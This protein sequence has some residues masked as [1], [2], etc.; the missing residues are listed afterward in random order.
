MLADRDVLSSIITHELRGPIQSVQAFLGVVL[1][2]QAGELT[3]VQKDFLASALFASKR[4]ER[5]VNDVH[6]LLA[7]EAGFSVTFRP[8]DL[9]ALLH[10]CVREL[11]LIA[12]GHDVHI[13]TEAA[14]DESWIV[15]ADPGRVEQIALN[16]L[17]NA[18]HYCDPGTNVVVRLR[19]SQE[20]VVCTVE[21]WATQTPSD[22]TASWFTPFVRG[23]DAIAVRPD[24]WGLGLVVAKQLAQAHG[25]NIFVRVAGH[26]VVVGFRL[27]KP[28][29]EQDDTEPA[30]SEPSA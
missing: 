16:L 23:A 6:V 30:A 14:D 21:N 15:W 22:A 1:G 25:G 11:S 12:A 10:N 27:P 8:V 3:A 4:L 17:E 19:R 28:P 9:L 20:R 26:K 24:G 7:R 29:T 18:I 13:S 5:L 2:G